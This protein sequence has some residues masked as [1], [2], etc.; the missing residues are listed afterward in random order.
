M[1]LMMALNAAVSGLRTTQSAMNITAQNVANANST[2]YTRR[3]MSPI[4]KLAGDQT[5]G[6]REGEIQRVLNVLTQ[7][8][9]RLELAGASYTSSMAAYAR[10]LDRLFG[11]PGE[12]GALDSMVNDFTGSLQALLNDSGSSAARLSV[13]D[14]AGVLASQ[15]S[16][17]SDSVQA[18]RTES[19]GRIG[20]AVERA[21]ELLTGIAGANQRILSNPSLND[22]GLL[23]ERDRL[24]NE[25][26][27]LMDV[28]A[29]YAADGSVSLSTTA[30]LSLFNGSQPVKLTFDGRTNLAPQSVY[31]TDPALRTVGTIT[32]VNGSGAGTDVIA[33]GM[34]RSGEIAA[35]IEM[36][37]KTLVQAQRQLDELAAGLSR[38]LSDY[39]VDGTAV[40]GPPDGFSLDM[41]GWK[42][43]NTLTLDYRQGAATGRIIFLATNGGAPAG[44][45]GADLGDPAATVV[46]VNIAGGYAAAAASIQAALTGAGIAVTATNPA[47]STLQLV[48]DG[49]PNTSDVTGLS[50]QDRNHA[51]ERTGPAA[52]LR[53][54]RRRQPAL[55]RLVR[56]RLALDRPRPAPR[57]EPGAR[58]RSPASRRLRGGSS[59]GRH[60]AAAIPARQPDQDAGDLYAEGGPERHRGFLLD[61]DRLRPPDGRGPGRQ[62]RARGTPRR[63]PERRAR[64]HRKPFRGGERRQ[65]G[66][67]DGA[68]R[69]APDRLRGQCPRHD[70]RARHDGPLDADLR[71]ERP[72]PFRRSDPDRSRDRPRITSCRCGGT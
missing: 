34:I 19:E 4:Q 32:A 53:R 38:A 24:I 5:T 54:Q 16:R 23:D 65:H 17:V 6:V 8:Q 3:T 69:P 31:S 28:Q 66:S 18:M 29:A 33:N 1:G 57:R 47:G 22:P 44:I 59:P 67:G 49:A 20:L 72:W 70:R 36:R 35:L 42:P 51:R 14:K 21:N 56:R 7:R 63:R 60:R 2:G 64:G 26:S 10:Q 12:A 68:A 39:K 13:L 45:T 58:R 25:L 40:A 48:D 62:C 15:L 41:T 43:G 61:G 71:S 55:Y 11:T 27:Q 37:D 46:Q 9:L 30:G 52:A 50:G